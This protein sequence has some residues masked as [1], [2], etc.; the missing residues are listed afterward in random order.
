MSILITGGAGFL[1]QHLVRHLLTTEPAAIVVVDRDIEC[2][3]EDFD[4]HL[5]P[6]SGD[7]L[8]LPFLIGT[9]EHYRVTNIVHL[10]YVLER[11]ERSVQ[12]QIETNVMGTTNIF[13][14]A[15]IGG[16]SRV[17]YM[18]SAYVYP[19]RRTLDG[20]RY[21]ED[22]PPAP[23]G[24]YGACKVFNEHIA[25]QYAE[26]YGL[27]AIGLRFTAVFGPGR[28]ERPGIAP[29]D[30]NVLPELASRGHP[31]VM[32]P[33]DQL[34]DWMYIADAVEVMRLALR[35]RRPDYRVFNAA[36]ECRPAGEITRIVRGLLP[37]AEI[38]VSDT[39]FVMTSLMH[40]HRLRHELGFAPK[41]TL[42]NAFAEYL[43]AVRSSTP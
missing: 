39:P 26:L 17:V 12:S 18:S 21:S 9:V 37:D 7:V 4:G 35:A 22:D 43:E 11:G 41:Y 40:T 10:A 14:A 23:D 20:R 13:E 33:D 34:C 42:E 32:P 5:T 31:V 2:D 16:I 24:V 8:D 6:I 19:H 36:S 28:G 38:A 30:L 3:L 29:D 15:R 1:G 27:D 25:G